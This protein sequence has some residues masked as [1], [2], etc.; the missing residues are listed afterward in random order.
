MN[1]TV[2]SPGAV[3]PENYPPYVEKDFKIN[4][5]L[6]IVESFLL[7]FIAELGDKTFIMNIILQIKTKTNATTIF[8]GSS[9][10]QILMNVIAIFVGFSI[11][12]CLYKNLIEYI[13]IIFFIIYGL[14]LLGD[15][16]NE[17]E[18]SFEKELAF[19][20]KIDE[21]RNKGDY[22]KL[23]ELKDS[24][25][26]EVSEPFRPN[27]TLKEEL[28]VIP[29]AEPLLEESERVNLVDLEKKFNG[30]KYE[31]FKGDGLMSK[32]I[33]DKPGEDEGMKEKLEEENEED[34]KKDE[35]L[36]EDKED[37]DKNEELEVFNED[38]TEETKKREYLDFK[39]FQ[40]IFKSMALAEFGDRTQISAMVMSSIFNL[41]GVLIGSCVALTLSSYLGAFHGRRV[42]VYLSERVLGLILGF[43]FLFYGIQIYIG[44]RFM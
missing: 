38:N 44:K 15:S 10:A 6:S 18:Q 7:I 31:K 26:I 24:K 2:A 21:L 30:K 14:F 35:F 43:I 20:D 16:L 13:G 12:Y 8:W 41:S 36:F 39:I 25:N 33:E 23:K 19:A 11:D 22:L 40:T 37:V 3:L 32:I 34:N 4:Y 9:S 17:V 5:Y 29:E 1:S 27:P 42:A 28:N